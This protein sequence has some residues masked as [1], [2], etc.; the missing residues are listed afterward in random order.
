MKKTLLSIFLLMAVTLF[1]QQQTVTYSINPTTFEDTTPVTITINGTSVNEASWGI[2]ATHALYLWSWS[3]DV[4]D[5]NQTDSPL[6]GTWTSSNEASKFTY[7]AGADT[8]TKTI[9]PS[10]YFARNGIGRIGF[11]IKAKD[12][13]G[14]KKSQDILVEVGS[15]Q[16]SLASP[17][18]NSSTIIA[19][20]ASFNIAATNTNGVA[21]YTLKSNGATLNTASTANYSYTH[22]NIASNQTYELIVVQGTTTIAKK[23][24]V[25]VNPNTVSEA[26]PAGLADGINYNVA[27]VTKAT[28]VLDAPSKDFVYVAGSFNNWQPT[29]AYAM[30]K[31]PASG[32]FWLELNGLVS[33]VNNTYQYWV[34]DTTPLASSPVMVKTAD[35]YATLVLSPYDDPWIPA[36]SYPNLPVYPSGQQFEVSVLKTGQTPYNWQVTN[37]IKPEK[38]KLVVYEVLVRDFDA[39]RNYQSLIDKIDY[40]KNL[41]INAIQLMPVME[42]EGNESWGYNTSF[43]MALDKFYGTSD[44]LKEFIDLCHQ[45]GIAVILDVALNHAFGR[46]PLVRMWMNDPDGD[47]FGSPTSENP[48]FNTAARH[49]YNVGEDFNHQSDK[50]QYYVQRVIKQWIQEYKIDGFRW[51]LTK[52]FTQNCTDSDNACTDAYQQD[53]VDVLKKYAD[54]SWSLDPTHY[55]IFEHLGTDAEEKQWADYRVAESPSKGIMMWGKMTNPYNQLSMGYASDSNI[56]RM[57]SSSRGFAANRLMGYA[58]SHDEERLMYKNVQYG[59]SSGSYNVKT[60]DTALS[61]MSAIGAVSLL[62]PGPKMIWHFGELGWENSIFTCNNNSVN[63]DYD[64]IGGDCKLDTKP[65]PQWTDNWLGN[66]NRSKIYNDWA[67]MITLKTVEPVF[68]GSATVLNANSLSV[69]I[70]ITNAALNSTQLKDVL[71]LA[72]FDVTAQNISTG[73]PYTG[74]WYNLMDNSA[75]NVSDINAPINL[76][77][78]EYRIYGNKTANLAIEDFEKEKTVSLHPNPVSSY[79]TLNFAVSKVQVYSVSGSLVKDFTSNNDLNHQFHVS[80]LKAGLYL[81]KAFDANGNSQT[82]KFIKK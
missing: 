82:M 23:F 75:I 17:I 3:Y 34:V 18:E 69:N 13:T 12:G 19:S 39:G 58:E 7:N 63:T 36:K 22:T 78:G 30:K 41:K 31:D 10:S 33:G 27:D 65:Q 15:F 37:F 42:F 24:S 49:S 64:A 62:V 44:K 74:T 6:N 5:T 32:K 9:T 25:V 53:R 79:F 61:R 14:D 1:A 20:G 48:Y 4:N 59:A 2:S 52:G 43:H 57:T 8:Y 47:G 77:P 60:L 70:K 45:N 73:F 38:E 55:T 21:S 16:V 66:T 81:V 51:D 11:L 80:D 46:N 29:S 67:K 68:L 54:Y 72:N 40:F 56:S 50:T 28:L 26:M 71:I 35:P 76:L